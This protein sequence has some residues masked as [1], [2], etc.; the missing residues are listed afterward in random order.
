MKWYVW[1]V[2]ILGFGGFF[3]HMDGQNTGL[4]CLIQ[5]WSLCAWKCSQVDTAQCHLIRLAVDRC[6]DTGDFQSPVQPK[7]FSDLVMYKADLLDSL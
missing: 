5:Y 3:N 7:L 4:G 6:L 2:G 1:G